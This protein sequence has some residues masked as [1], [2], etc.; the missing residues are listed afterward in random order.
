MVYVIE[1]I[2]EV[3]AAA[4]GRRIGEPADTDATTAAPA[5][6]ESTAEAEHAAQ[7]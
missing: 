5:V 3:L 4:Q 6:M 1:S 2:V 7:Q